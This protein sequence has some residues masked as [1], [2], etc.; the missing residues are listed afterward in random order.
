M[1]AKT[2]DSKQLKSRVLEIKQRM[3]ASCEK[4]VANANRQIQLSK[5]KAVKEIDALLK[6]DLLYSSGIKRPRDAHIEEKC[7]VTISSNDSP[8]MD[9]VSVASSTISDAASSALDAPIQ[10]TT[11]KQ[12]ANKQEKPGKFKEEAK[13]IALQKTSF[14]LDWYRYALEHPTANTG[15]FL[16]LV[17]TDPNL[18]QKYKGSPCEEMKPSTLDAMGDLV[19]ANNKAREVTKNPSLPTILNLNIEPTIIANRIEDLTKSLSKKHVRALTTMTADFLRI[20]NSR[21]GSPD[22]FWDSDALIHLGVWLQERDALLPETK[23]RLKGKTIKVNKDFVDNM[24]VTWR[25]QIGSQFLRSK[26]RAEELTASLLGQNDLPLAIRLE[27]NPVKGY[28]L[29]ATADIKAHQ[30]IC[31]YSSCAVTIKKEVAEFIY[32]SNEYLFFHNDQFW[33]CHHTLSGFAHYINDGTESNSCNVEILSREGFDVPWVRTTRAV[34]KNS[35][36]ERPYGI[37]FWQSRQTKAFTILGEY[38]NKMIKA[39]Q[40]ATAPSL[41]QVQPASFQHAPPQIQPQ[42]KIPTASQAAAPQPAV[43]S[44]RTAPTISKAAFPQQP[45]VPFALPSNIQR[46]K[47]TAVHQAVITS[48]CSVPA[49]VYRAA[50]AQYNRP[51]VPLTELQQMINEVEVLTPK[52]TKG[53]VG[54][55]RLR[56]KR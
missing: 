9:D 37:P 36:L 26:T 1:A 53:H 12:Q 32:T 29:Y 16:A 10:P 7:D 55:K 47:P 40:Q 3:L 11:E 48:A 21:V 41:S 20:N 42:F 43:P 24:K 14:T 28:G 56:I 13:A 52:V 27:A 33:D 17:K 35:A 4:A 50:I 51:S 19:R 46:T 25:A 45:F 34:A 5:N 39:Y 8:D 54:V 15:D 31:P 44:T 2:I 23:S 38:A 6:P 22:Y 18:A 30:W 49:G